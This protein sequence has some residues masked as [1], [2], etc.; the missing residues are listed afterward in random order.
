VVAAPLAGYLIRV[1]PQRI[2]LWLVG[3]VVLSQAII[4]IYGLFST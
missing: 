1:M 4:S 2:A 3:S